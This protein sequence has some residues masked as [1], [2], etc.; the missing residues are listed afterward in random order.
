MIIGGGGFVGKALIDHLS[1]EEPEISLVV[2]DA[3][4]PPADRPGMEWLTVDIADREQVDAAFRR[5]EPELVFHLASADR[6]VGLETLT[7]V[8]VFGTM[9]VLQALRVCQQRRRPR[10]LYVSSSAVYGPAVDGQA[11]SETG[12]MRPV[13]EY[14]ISKAAAELIVQREVAVSDVEAV[15]VRPFNIFGPGQPS[16]FVCADMVRKVVEAERAGGSESIPI[17][18][19]A[20]RR[21]FVDVRDVVKAFWAVIRQGQPGGTYNV[22]CGRALSVQ[23]IADALGLS[24]IHI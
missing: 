11:S 15:I 21:D 20:A 8:N 24:L 6:R 10:V 16:G 14:G 22:S 2:V 1:A 7:R 23:Q 17:R 13:S 19:P 9:H 18:R 3:A 4:D 12:R 5:V